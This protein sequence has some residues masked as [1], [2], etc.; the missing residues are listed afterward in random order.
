MT[1]YLPN[2]AGPV[3]LVLDLH[4]AHDRF[5]SISDLNLNGH[6]HYP[7]DIDKSLNEV[8]ANKI[9]KYRADYNRWLYSEFVRLL[10]LQA[11]GKLTIFLQFQEFSSC[12]L[13]VDTSTSTARC[14]P[15]IL[16]RVWATFLP[17][18]ELYVGS[19]YSPIT[20]ANFSSMNLV[21]IFWC[22]TRHQVSLSCLI[23]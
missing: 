4:I 1:T 2:V 7:N 3:P 21:F 11:L 12:N 13:T 17:R 22:S 5:G 19:T 20:L 10:F 15:H 8:A 23:G 18:L 16:N 6:L 9:R 14:S